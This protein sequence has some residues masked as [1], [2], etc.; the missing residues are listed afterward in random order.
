M[1][2]YCSGAASEGS[3]GPAVASGL[4]GDRSAAGEVAEWAAVGQPGRV[5][6]QW[7]QGYNREVQS[8]CFSFF[9]YHSPLFLKKIVCPSLLLF[10]TS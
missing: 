7:I 8:H 4:V 5:L 6:V 9:S 2:S 3:D 10:P 1:G